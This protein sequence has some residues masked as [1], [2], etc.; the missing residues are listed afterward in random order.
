M[1]LIFPVVA[2][3]L[4]VFLHEPSVGWSSREAPC[5]VSE[6]QVHDCSVV[7]LADESLHLTRA[8]KFR[9]RIVIR[10]TSCSLC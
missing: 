1:P 10:T 6:V 7:S 3:A 8:R 9:N 4:S 5:L 2:V